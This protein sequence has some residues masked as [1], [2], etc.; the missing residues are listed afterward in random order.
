MADGSINIDLLL[1]DQTDQTW[2]NFKTKAE[3]E[4][5][6]GYEKFKDAFKGDPLVAKLEAQ[7]DKAGINDFRELLNQLPKAKQT[8]LFAKAEKGEAIDFQQFIRDI[9]NAKKI[10]LEAQAKRAGI[11]NFEK[12][13]NK[14]PKKTLTDLQ[15]RAEKG[16]VINFEKELRKLPSK[17]VSS[18]ELNDNASIGLRSLKKQANEVGDKFHRLKDIM[19]GTFAAN[20][21]MG[22]IH[23]ITSGI[24]DMTKAGME[25]NKE[26][27]TMKTVWT[28]LTTEAPKDGKELVD[29][30]NNLSQH[31]IYAADNINEMAQSFYHVH[32]NVEETKKWT[33]AFVALGS[34]LHMTGPQISESGEMF[35]KIVA[36]GKASAEDMAVMINRFPM[37]GEALQKATGKSMKELY[38]MSAAGKLSATQFTEAL[39]YLGEKYK[40]GTAEAMTSMQGMSMYLK[41]RLS[42]LSGEVMKSSFNMSKS[43]TS[44]LQKITSDKSMQKFADG[45]SG[46]L[47]V[48]LG[49]ISKI[50]TYVSAHSKDI[51]GIIGNIKQIA[52]LLIGGAWDIAKDT[53]NGIAT[54]FGLISGNS[55]KAH[56]PLKTLNNVLTEIAKHKDTI[57]AV[58]A[59]IAVAFSVKKLSDF[60]GGLTTVAKTLKLTAASTKN[61][62][63]AQWVYNAALKDNPLGIFITVLAAVGA[64]FYE[65]Y[66]HND[67][68]R[69]FINGIGK[70]V[71]NLFDKFKD[72]I[73]P[74]TDSLVVLGKS[75]G[76]VFGD[77]FKML[78]KSFSPFIK[79]FKSLFKGLGGEVGGIFNSIGKSIGNLTKPFREAGKKGGPIQSVS[80]ALDSISQWF[81]SNKSLFTGTANVIGKVLG[82]AFVVLGAAIR[83]IVEL[84][85]PLFKPAFN[86][87]VAVVK[88]ALGVI[89]NAFK[90][91]GNTIKLVAD[92]VT[93]NWKNIG[94]DL[95]GILGGVVGIFSSVFS[96]IA[97]VVGNIFHALVKVIDKALWS[98]GTSAKPLEKMGNSIVKGFKWAINWFKHDWKEILLFIVNPFSGA[99][100]LVYKHNKTFKNAINSLVKSV[101]GF[102]KG[103]WNSITKGTS[104]TFGGIVKSTQNFGKS[105]LKLASNIWNG[106]T[107]GVED[108]FKW[109]KKTWSKI[110]DFLTD[111]WDD[112]KKYVLKVADKLW[113]GITDGISDLFK[114]WRKTWNKIGDFL[115]DLWGDMKKSVL[116]TADRLWDGISDGVS[117]F[118]NWFKKTWNRLKDFFGDTWDNIKS[119]GSKGI[120]GLK[121]NLGD[122]LGRIGQGF[123]DTW[124]GVQDGFSKLWDGMKS[125]ASAG[126]N[127]V[128]KPINWG[129]DGIN[130]LIHDFGG[131]KSAIG[132]IPK[133]NFATGTGAL[134]GGRRPITRPTL[135][136]LNDGN[137]S[138]ET[139]NQEIVIHPN[140]TPELIQGRN[141]QRMLAPGTEVLNASES[142]MFMAMQGA[143][144]FANGTG[145]WGSLWN[146]VK[147]A[148]S[149][150]ANVAGD[151]WDGTKN[152]ASSAWS[153]MKAGVD[154]FTKMF[155]FI[156]NAVAHPI[157]TLESVFNPSSKG[158]PGVFSSIGSGMFKKSKDQATDWW[159]ELWSMANDSSNSGASGSNKGDDYLFKNKGA[160]SGADPW[161][162]FYKECV[163]FVASRLKQM[164][165]SPSLFSGLG[166][167]ADWVNAKVKHTNN[168]KP[169]DV[170]VYAGGSDYGNHVAMVTGVQGGKISGEEYNFLPTAAHKYH[171]YSGRPISGATTFL[172]FGKSIASTVKDVAANSGL[173]KLIKK[174]T[175]GMMAWIQ[176]YIAP[177]NSDSDGSAGESA[178]PNGSHKNWLSQA[179]I[180]GDFSKW[181]YIIN[182]ESGWNPKAKNPSSDAYG[183]GQALP[184]SKMAKYG[185]DYMS[186]PITQLK[187]MKSYVNERYGGIDG[188]YDWWKSHNWY[189]N[190]GKTNG[191]G[192][193]GEVQGEDEWVTN[194]H[195]ST[196][197]ET[198]I[199][200]IKDTAQKQPN[201]FAAKLSQI[202]NSAKSGMQNVVA[203]QPIIAGGNFV[204]ANGN[205]IDL[206]GDVNL[207]IKMDSG[208]IAHATYPKIKMLQNQEIQLEGQKTGN[209]YGY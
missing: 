94:K 132:S 3:K 110:G 209:T 47:S 87:V 152:V 58:G 193:V 155:K 161:G 181:N 117:G 182:H 138:P 102:F 68:F 106:I 201:S 46:A 156:T 131:S 14:L 85:L 49:G 13:L 162:Y 119:I 135:A 114:W 205:G 37:F 29:Y 145:F 176:K 126:I 72:A 196:A 74:I 158:I 99:F 75:L 146:G 105:V 89:G 36:G 116:K 70:T 171:A 56:D 59:A 204:G 65:L 139:G 25:Y 43:A 184:P 69:S 81:I 137:D 63:A 96:T 183:I 33:D 84:I 12:L 123:S 90:I 1:N 80:E 31:S 192:I 120:N 144:P 202:V 4:G 121:N 76:E 178:L 18:V 45:I 92:L 163:S 203:P 164:G 125:M 39:D 191:I 127:L 55:K 82:G 199:G 35:A 103:M 8:E 107:D 21:L 101:V 197:D 198:I 118:Y 206:S 173:A 115:T 122:V 189:A 52:G 190:G 169:G 128:I 73:K 54:A 200:S 86:I 108:L 67:K 16:E 207:T 133:V 83:G 154:K 136:V 113:D 19:I 5:K 2:N 188:A 112:T 48:A 51:I 157:K 57:K 98:L 42:V 41:S 6:N 160:D 185:S 170:A 95:K 172:D 179:G 22:G 129:I 23:A 168:P 60:V 32:S 109:W 20:A 50:I 167:G 100:A 177:L 194:P 151:V 40:G 134:S 142:A 38:A 9:P 71:A 44:A 124:K 34:T 79:L 175:G 165:V 149:A 195:R 111:L 180:S 140:G 88:G 187:W 186:N 66:K 159:K 17:V 11:D 166:N 61:L 91:L 147:S 77:S 141:T 104:Q 64:A 208:E 15:A 78:E 148:G 153:G 97:K 93:L 30:I 62:T 150:V 130:S 143:V 174:Q 28:A 24:K 26:Q 10:M 27:D 53:I 7:A